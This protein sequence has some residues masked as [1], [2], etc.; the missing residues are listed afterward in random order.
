MDEFDDFRCDRDTHRDS[1]IVNPHHLEVLS[2]ATFIPAMEKS[3]FKKNQTTFPATIA[4]VKDAPDKVS[5]SLDA[6]DDLFG[7]FDIVIALKRKEFVKQGLLVPP[8][9]R[10][11]C[12]DQIILVPSD[13]IGSVIEE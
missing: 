8:H 7:E 4:D 3:D 9:R 6:E 1:S 2:S 13:Q 10:S 12:S 11:N 5:S